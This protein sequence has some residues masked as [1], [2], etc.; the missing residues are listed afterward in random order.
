M[1]DVHPPEHTPHSWR[2]FFI[3]IATIVIGLLIAIG[4]EQTVEWVHRRH[5]IRE[6]R[7]DLLQER[8]EN[9]RQFPASTA[10][11]YLEAALL[12]NNLQVLLFLQQH[13]GTPEEK[14]PGTLQWDFRYVLGDESVWKNAQQTQVLSLLPR[15]EAEK[16][17]DFYQWM[18]Q[19]DRDILALIPATISARRYSIVDPNPSHLTPAQ[20]SEEIE[21]TEKAIEL[22]HIWGISLLNVHGEFSDFAPA[23]T[24]DEIF[25]FVVRPRS[26]ADQNKLAVVEAITNAKLKPARDAHEAADKNAGW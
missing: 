7:E 22:T 19:I 4:L 11:Y 13:P 5:E 6:T 20:V 2:D 18:E 9:R 10:D 3:H 14:L 12:E 16:D 21:L 1:L 15:Q 24:L 23:P 8:E 26:L 25:S 17:A